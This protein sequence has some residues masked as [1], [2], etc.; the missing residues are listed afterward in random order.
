MSV[1]APFAGETIILMISSKAVW[2][3]VRKWSKKP[4]KLFTGVLPLK[5]FL[6]NYSCA[7]FLM[8]I[9]LCFCCDQT[10]C[11]KLNC[12]L[13][14]LA[15]FLIWRIQNTWGYQRSTVGFLGLDTK[16]KRSN[17][18][19]YITWHIL[20]SSVLGIKSDN[21]NILV[22]TPGQSKIMGKKI[23]NGKRICSQMDIFI[24]HGRI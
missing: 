4:K 23:K 16:L 10:K 1:S 7:N 6:S 12:V 13:Q 15:Q 22:T 14:T 24:L 19:I 2:R 5:L 21:G 3:N 20:T 8:K 11:Q 18:V 9:F 17:L